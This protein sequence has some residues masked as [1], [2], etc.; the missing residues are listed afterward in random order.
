MPNLHI[1]NLSTVTPE[2]AFLVTPIS[3][4][5]LHTVLMQQPLPTDV[6]GIVLFD[7]ILHSGNNRDRF[8]VYVVDKGVIVEESRRPV[9]MHRKHPIRVKASEVLR[10]YPKVMNYSI[11][12]PPQ[13]KLLLKG[14]T[15]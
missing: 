7:T 5:G 14:L 6:S 4:Q 9:Y 3:Y 10:Q 15:I 12:I 13:R 8:V 1:E 11:I 2:F